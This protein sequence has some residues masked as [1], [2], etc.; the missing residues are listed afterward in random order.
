MCV[1]TQISGTHSGLWAS[2]GSCKQTRE[3]WEQRERVTQ[4]IQGGGVHSVP[5]CAQHG[6]GCLLTPRIPHVL[7][8]RLSA[9]MV[10]RGSWWKLCQSRGRYQPEFEGYSPTRRARPQQ[11]VTC[12]SR[13]VGRSG[14]ATA[15][16]RYFNNSFMISFHSGWQNCSQNSCEEKLRHG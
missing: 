15:F 16:T 13:H 3:T 6:M 4:E 7:S 5:V 14:R 10:S 2:P 1:L 9:P 12:Y 11:T 8:P